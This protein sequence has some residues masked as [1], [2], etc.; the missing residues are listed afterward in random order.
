MRL[1]PCHERSSAEKGSAGRRPCVPP[2][3][4]HAS[5]LKELGG[6]HDGDEEEA[7]ER[8]GGKAEGGLA[9][10]ETVEVDEPHEE[11]AVA[12]V[13]V[14]GNAADVCGGGEEGPRTLEAGEA[15][16]KLGGSG[17]VSNNGEQEQC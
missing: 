3:V 17:A 5:V 8:R 6:E 9:V 7:L 12:R 10:L 1:N 13:A 2:L 16:R 4:A 15:R 14:L 11:A